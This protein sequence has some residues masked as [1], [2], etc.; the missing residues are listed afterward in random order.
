MANDMTT[1]PNEANF[2]DNADSIA[3]VEQYNTQISLNFGIE[4]EQNVDGIEMGVLENGISYL[5]ES[6]LAQ[7]CGVDRRI[8]SEISKEW[9]D[10]FNDTVL[11][12]ER[13]LFIRD[14]LS[15]DEYLD[16]KLYLE[17]NKDGSVHYAYPDIV[18]M[19]ILEYFVFEAKEKS[20]IAQDNYRKFAHKGFQDFIYSCLSYTPNDKWKYYLDRVSILQNAVPNGYFS[21][22]NEIS[23]IIADL[24]KAGLTVN[25]KTIP[26]ISVGRVWSTHW[27]SNDSINNL[28]D[29]IR[30]Q[31]NYPEYYPQSRKNPQ[32]PW[33]Y[34]DAALPEFRN[35]FKLTYLQTQFPVYI[36]KK[37]NILPGGKVEATT[38][39]NMYKSDRIK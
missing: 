10:T 13:N 24:I 30:Y 27:E 26:D 11:T 9:E 17:A 3:E 34:P 25:H 14:C 18:C 22:F 4:I 33:A 32:A 31:H 35:W 21:V 36:L 29:R 1:K 8:I 7:L 39:G 15:K 12:E 5:T 28:G 19:A 16:E 6:G 23:G 2:D 37:S 38:I 20:Q